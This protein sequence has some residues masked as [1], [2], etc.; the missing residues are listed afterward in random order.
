[1]FT[2]NIYVIT[3]KIL[4]SDEVKECVFIDKECYNRQLSYLRDHKEYYKILESYVLDMEEV[5]L[6]G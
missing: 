1:M 5:A 6:H 2:D 4:R 3:W